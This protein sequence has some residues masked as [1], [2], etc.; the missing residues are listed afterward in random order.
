MCARPNVILVGTGSELF[1]CAEARP[2]LQA[3]GILAR[4][5]SF[6][7][8]QLFDKQTVEYQVRAVDC[9]PRESVWKSL[10]VFC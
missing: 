6:P 10:T 2:K 3:A 9:D 1:L 4:V 5:V 8:W 7:C